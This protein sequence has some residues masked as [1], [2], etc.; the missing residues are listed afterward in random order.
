MQGRQSEAAEIIHV[1]SYSANDGPMQ[2]DGRLTLDIGNG[3]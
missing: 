1:E 2:S 3:R